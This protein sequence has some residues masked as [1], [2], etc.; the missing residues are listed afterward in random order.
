MTSNDPRWANQADELSRPGSAAETRERLVEAAVEVFLEKGYDRVRVQ[1][2]TRA[3]GYTTG[4][5]YAHFESRTAVLGEAITRQGDALINQMATV[6]ATLEPGGGQAMNVFA[7]LM[8][9]DPRPLDRLLTEAM[10]LAVRDD[11]SKAALM[12]A[13]ENLQSQLAALVDAGIAN[14]TVAPDMNRQA[15]TTFFMRMLLGTVVGRAL[16]LDHPSR[17]EMSTFLMHLRDAI[18]ETN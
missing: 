9:E 7:D 15:M 2:I 17:D 8:T 18:A 1:D 6:A 12:P 14:G 11:E 5:L 3:A 10:A 13:F 16:D 4:A